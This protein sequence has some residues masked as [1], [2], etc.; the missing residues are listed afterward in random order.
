MPIFEFVVL[1]LTEISEA[2][3]DTLSVLAL[4]VQ[5]G[6]DGPFQFD[7]RAFQRIGTTTQRMPVVEYERRLLQRLHSR[8]RWENQIADG[9]TLEQ[10]DL[11][12]ISKTHRIAAEVNRLDAQY[13]SPED[14]LDHFGL[15]VDGSLTQA[16]I[17]LFG[18][19]NEF[20]GG[21]RA[22]SL[23]SLSADWDGRWRVTPN[24]AKSR[25]A[26]RNGPAL[27]SPNDISQTTRTKALA[28]EMAPER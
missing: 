10:L 23:H 26:V 12:E 3:T 8:R 14:T 2:D 11:D 6:D 5:P 18:K 13:A 15:R 19:T 1:N 20:G 17:V 24:R 28:A 27:S 16:A 25:Q 7:G 9:W 22:R 21:G 4:E